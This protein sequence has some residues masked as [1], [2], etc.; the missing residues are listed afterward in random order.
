MARDP[1]PDLSV[2]ITRR[3]W[4]CVPDPLL[5]LSQTGAAFLRGLAPHAEIW[6]GPEFMN[7]LDGWT[8]FDR[9]PALLIGCDGEP[10][11]AEE[12]RHALRA[13]ARLRDEA[14]HVGGPLCWVRDAM[15][16]SC[17]PSGT[18][19][20]VVA[21]WEVMAEAL[22]ARLTTA[23][24]PSSPLVAAT[25]DAVALGGV[26]PAAAIL[27]LRDT[28]WR[29][30]PPSLCRHLQ[31]WGLPCRRLDFADDMVV[32]ERT[33]LLNLLIEAG[34]AGFLWGGLEL[35]VVHLMVPGAARLQLGPGF[36]GMPDEPDFLAGEPPRPMQGAWADAQAFWYDLLMEHADAA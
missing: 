27:S 23:K 5:C 31:A 35:V 34:L 1:W 6:L 33:M 14:G 8:L 4:R 25:R 26:L 7:I 19:G 9:E 28:A 10:S 21:R 11:V 16:E 13:W 22:D 29:T 17:L 3:R 18:D 30:Q 20:S 36:S 2:Q 15:R 12:M 32:R 24:E